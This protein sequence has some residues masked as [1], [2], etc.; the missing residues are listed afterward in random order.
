MMM[1][2][3]GGTHEQRERKKKLQLR[4][5]RSEEREIRKQTHNETRIEAKEGK[6][7]IMMEEKRRG[8]TTK[9]THA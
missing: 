6:T 3:D 8:Q 2:L 9:N 7:T 4:S 1:V 5:K